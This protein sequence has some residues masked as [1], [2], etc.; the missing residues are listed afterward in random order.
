MDHRNCMLILEIPYSE[1]SYPLHPQTRR[2]GTQWAQEWRENRDRVFPLHRCPTRIMAVTSDR[3]ACSRPKGHGGPKSARQ[4]GCPK[5]RFPIELGDRTKGVAYT[6]R[7]SHNY[8]AT[9]SSFHTSD[10]DAWKP[11]WPSGQVRGRCRAR[12]LA[13]DHRYRVTGLLSLLEGLVYSY[14]RCYLQEYGCICK[15]QVQ[16]YSRCKYRCCSKA[17][18]R[19]GS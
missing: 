4:V 8:F 9:S 1:I 17:T 6:V 10:C 13:D 14:C 18:D 12:I 5:A 2:F 11:T 16:P 19:A 7:S 3:K 15:W